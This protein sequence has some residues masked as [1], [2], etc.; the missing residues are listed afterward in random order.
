MGHWTSYARAL[1]R[2]GFVCTGCAW[3]EATEQFPAGE[4]AYFQLNG[5]R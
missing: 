5:G 2:C 3:A 4:E 1:E